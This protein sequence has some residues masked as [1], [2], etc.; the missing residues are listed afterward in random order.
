MPVSGSQIQQEADHCRALVVM[1]CVEGLSSGHF[2]RL[3]S[4]YRA[5]HSEDYT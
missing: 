2:H 4:Y 3:E 1:L 5:L